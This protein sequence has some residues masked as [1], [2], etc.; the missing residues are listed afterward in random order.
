MALLDRLAAIG[1]KVVPTAYQYLECFGEY[2]EFLNLDVEEYMHNLTK[3]DHDDDE[4]EEVDAIEANTID[5][6]KLWD[7]AK[8]HREEAEKVMDQVW[9]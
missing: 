7:A 3:G 8:K 9:L 6:Q 5:L 1:K 4:E 2:V